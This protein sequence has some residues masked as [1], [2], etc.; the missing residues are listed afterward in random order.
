[1][2]PEEGTDRSKRRAEEALAAFVKELGGDNLPKGSFGKLLDDWLSKAD[3][4]ASTRRTY[5]GYVENWLRPELGNILLRTLSSEH[6]DG[7]YAKMRQAGKAQRT[8][9]QVHAVAHRALERGVEW[10]RLPKNP[11]HYADKPKVPR[12]NVQ[13]P[14]P[15][16]VRA[17][18]EAAESLEPLGWMLGTLLALYALTG[19]RRGE[20]CCLRWADIDWSGGYM[21][22]TATKTDEVYDV[23]LDEIGL[24]ILERHRVTMARRNAELGREM[25]ADDYLF[26]SPRRMDQHVHPDTVT[27]FFKNAAK[28]AGRDEHLHQLR[29]FAAT[30]LIAAGHDVKTVQGRLGHRSATT[31]LNI[32]ARQWERNDRA[33]ARTLSK[34][35]VPKTEKDPRPEVGGGSRGR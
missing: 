32:Y 1:M 13:A 27:H 11:A 15:S 29:H 22:V 16:A 12:P 8:I 20:L 10:G 18:L 33:A 2:W 28:A 26:P 21:T 14:S 24:A 31:T 30:Q 35:L 34:A 3:L 5:E 7:L 25:K 6:F 19:R 23:D 17:I 9:R 4:A